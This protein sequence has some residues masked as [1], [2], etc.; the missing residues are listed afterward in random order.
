MS[1]VSITATSISLSWS[2]PSDSVV[3]SSKVTWQ[4]LSSSG[5]TY[6]SG[7]ITDTSYTIGGLKSTTVYNITITV[8]NTIVSTDS[9]PIIISTG[10]ECMAICIVALLHEQ[11]YITFSYSLQSQTSMTVVSLTT[12][13]QLL[14]E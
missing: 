13:Q 12:L 6:T 11:F 9:H 2:V 1:V 14:V 10:T 8:T 5:I 4:E 3:T 7:S